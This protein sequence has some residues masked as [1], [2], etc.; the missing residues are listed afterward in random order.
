M[1]KG[2][3]KSADD[4]VAELEGKKAEYVSKID[5]LKDKIKELDAKISQIRAAERQKEIEHLLDLIK[6]S[7]KTPEEVLA[8]LQ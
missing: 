5:G 3:A 4:L 6:A 2:V 8:S 1:P 7:G